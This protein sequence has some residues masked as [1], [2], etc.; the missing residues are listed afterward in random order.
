MTD[1][2]G[3]SGVDKITLFSAWGLIRK[4]LDIHGRN[5]L[6]LL[7]QQHP[8]YLAYFDFSDDTTALSLVDNK[9]LF[10]QSILA[11]KTFGALI[12]Y[13]LEDA[14][15]FHETLRKVGRWHG[16][17]QARDVLIIGNVLLAYLKQAL[18]R[19]APTTLDEAFR[20]LFVTISNRFPTR[21]E[22]SSASD[23][24]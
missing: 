14:V 9:S 23:P 15:L 22:A 4:D 16:N 24:I 3:L 1:P 11:I 19:Q 7:F 10:S 21:A 12:E 6:L 17:I 8:E 18:G 2:T 13:G 20:N 5:I